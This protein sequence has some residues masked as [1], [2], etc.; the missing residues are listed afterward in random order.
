MQVAEGLAEAH[1]VCQ[2]VV[3]WPVQ[4]LLKLMPVIP[5]P[6][7]GERCVAKTPLLYRAWCRSR[8]GFAQA[9]ET[10]VTA[11]FDAARQGSSAFK[12]AVGRAY[13][14][15]VATRVGRHAAALLW[16]LHNFVIQ[17]LWHISSLVPLMPGTP[18]WTWPWVHSCTSPLGLSKTKGI[19]R[20]ALL[21]LGA[22]CQAVHRRYPSRGPSWPRR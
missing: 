21:S 6:P 18:C 19:V 1:S 14:L 17:H 3:A 5:K 10:E 12:A 15:E 9:C 20:T 22:S 13:A 16:D 4:M 2:D 7:A 8:R 11:D